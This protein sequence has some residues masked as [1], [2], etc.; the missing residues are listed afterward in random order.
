MLIFKCLVGDRF[1]LFRP[2][3]RCGNVVFVG[4]GRITKPELFYN[5]GAGYGL[6]L[7]ICI[8][9]GSDDCRTQWIYGSGYRFCFNEICEKE[10]PQKEAVYMYFS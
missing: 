2:C 9:P 1:C 10:M 5:S 8:F 4:I 6:L 3:M 7:L